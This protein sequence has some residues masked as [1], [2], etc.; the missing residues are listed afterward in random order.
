MTPSNI[1]AA[2]AVDILT[3]FEDFVDGS[4]TR[5][6]L[7]LGFEPLAYEARNAID[8]S[9][10]SFGYGSDACSFA[11]IG[12]RDRDAEGGDMKLDPQSLFLL[13][14]ALDPLLLV[15]ADEAA[16]RILAQAYRT[17]FNLDAAC[18]VF[19]RPTVV[20]RDLTALLETAEGKQKAWTLLKT[21]PKR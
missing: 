10:L 18:R 5:I 6:A 16:A 17:A 21:L 2:G 19:G 11:S 9:L 1:Y 20:F 7:A 4:S 15:V 3:I 8:K 13:I 14:E 12:P